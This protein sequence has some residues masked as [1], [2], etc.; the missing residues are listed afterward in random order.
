MPGLV[1]GE[2]EKSEIRKRSLV[3]RTSA[4]WLGFSLL[5]VLTLLGNV[6]SYFSVLRLEQEDVRTRSEFQSRDQLLDQLANDVYRASAVARDYLLESDERRAG[7]RRTDLETIRARIF[8]ALATYESNSPSYERANLATLHQSVDYF[9][10]LVEPPLQ[11]TG[12]Q[13]KRESDSYLANTLLP[14][15]ERVEKLVRDITVRDER[16]VEESERRLQAGYL[17]LQKQ[18]VF[19]SLSA[20]LGGV[21]AAFLS[22]QIGR[23][24]V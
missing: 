15:S 24:H 14:N 8:N 13:R 23:A 5:I 10:S 18:M 4:V 9:L 12:E 2:A 19:V 17:G 20:L 21:A 3:A 16:E 11:W 6:Y 1:Q 22:A 7:T